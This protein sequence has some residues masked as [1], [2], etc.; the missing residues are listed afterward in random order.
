MSNMN[1]A[2]KK[3]DDFDK[4]KLPTTVKKLIELIFDLKM[5]NKQMIQIGYNTKKMPLGKLSKK[6][7]EKGYEILNKLIAEIK[8]KNEKSLIDELSGEFYT[9]I[10]HDFGFIKMINFSLNS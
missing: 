3:E 9:N 10:P 1:N 6:S 7:I 2:N 8:G 4:S 5:M